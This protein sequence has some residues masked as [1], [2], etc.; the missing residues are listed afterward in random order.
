MNPDFNVGDW[1]EWED[2]AG[3]V[4]TIRFRVTRVRTIDNKVIVVP[5]TT[6]ATSAVTHPY[7]RDRLRMVVDLGISYDADI[8]TA[9]SALYDEVEATEGVLEAPAPSILVQ[10]LG[11]DAVQLRVIF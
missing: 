2:S 4:E 7:N 10:E 1:L 5:N 6:L 3:V 8:E 11:G 9:T